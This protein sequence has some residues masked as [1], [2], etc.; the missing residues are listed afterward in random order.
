M[1]GSVAEGSRYFWVSNPLL[2]SALKKKTNKQWRSIGFQGLLF[3]MLIERVMNARDVRRTLTNERSFWTR[4]EVAR[5]QSKVKR[6]REIKSTEKQRKELEQNHR[7]AEARTIERGD[8]MRGR[9]EE[10]GE[11]L[12]QP[13]FFKQLCFHSTG[14]QGHYPGVNPQS[15]GAGS[16]P[17]Q[18]R[19]A[20]H[21]QGGHEQK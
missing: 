14:H 5:K 9:Q 17:G 18:A 1:H 21:Q 15:D 20:V 19:V 12:R 6:Q 11:W 8:R 7:S 4:D 10:R 16:L 13:I 2:P 3:S